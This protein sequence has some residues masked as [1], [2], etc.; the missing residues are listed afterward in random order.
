M[1]NIPI[2]TKCDEKSYDRRAVQKPWTRI[3]YQS[4]H[5]ER[6]GARPN[7]HCPGDS[8]YRCGSPDPSSCR[9]D[10]THAR[11]CHHPCSG[12]HT[13]LAGW[14]NKLSH[15]CC[16]FSWHAIMSYMIMSVQRYNPGGLEP[17]CSSCS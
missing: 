10:R 12:T 6:P 1:A 13:G 7:R 16:T 4:K 14:L 11:A 2:Y 9:S 17:H 8:P 3:L 15:S 5:L